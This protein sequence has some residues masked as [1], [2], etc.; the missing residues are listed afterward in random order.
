MP[1][2]WFSCR[3]NWHHGMGS[4]LITSGRW[5][6]FWLFTGPLL[7]P[8]KWGK[9]REHHYC[10]VEV[11]TP[12]VCLLILW[13]R[14]S[15]FLCWTGGVGQCSLC[16][17]VGVGQLLSISFLLAP[18]LVLWLERVGFCWGF[19]VRS[20]WCFLVAGFFTPTSGMDEAK[21]NLRDLINVLFLKSRGS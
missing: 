18:L 2:Y 4:G 8:P 9:G 1:Y 17:L 3:L 7:A 21:R 5:W 12:L 11:Q 16:G 20:V 15:I 13:G 10:W 19:V 14:K 6:K